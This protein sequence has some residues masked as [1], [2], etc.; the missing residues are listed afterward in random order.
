MKAERASISRLTSGYAQEWF[1][2]INIDEK[3][4]G[5]P[6]E[7]NHGAIQVEAKIAFHCYNESPL[8][9][10]AP[11]TRAAVQLNESINT[12]YLSARFVPR[13]G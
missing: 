8:E 13:R 11:M 9:D 3:F 5:I 4:W 1:E 12:V 2:L 10:N 6:C 7:G